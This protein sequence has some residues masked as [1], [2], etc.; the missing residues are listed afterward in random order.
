VERAGAGARVA[1]SGPGR[2]YTID[3]HTPEYLLGG[4]ESALPA[5]GQLLEHLPPAACVRVVVE[6][7]DAGARLELPAH[8][9]TTI[10]WC[11]S[12]T[13]AAPGD[14]LRNAVQALDLAPDTRIWAAGEAAAMQRL[15]K[16]FFEE[17]GIPRA[18]TTIRGYWKHGRAGGDDE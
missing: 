14:A 13:D 10:E 18:H 16:Y 6:L 4:D 11:E 12:D 5:I 7:G 1:L 9:R 3:R 15:R 17:R 2:G 8:P